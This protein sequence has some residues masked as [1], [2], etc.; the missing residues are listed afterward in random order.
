M[1]AWSDTSEPEEPWDDLSLA[2]EAALYAPRPYV[3]RTQD[4]VSPLPADFPVTDPLPRAEGAQFLIDSMQRE[5]CRTADCP[6]D[7]PET[8][9][10]SV[11]NLCVDALGTI[12]ACAAG[13]HAHG[14]QLLAEEI[15][16]LLDELVQ[17]L[18]RPYF[19]RNGLHVSGYE[20]D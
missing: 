13:L 12:Q 2:E 20:T 18:L 14:E 3:R 7:D 11:A 1:T 6:L 17:E 4:S 9:A 16:V 8:L 15:I 10:Q 5:R 19:E